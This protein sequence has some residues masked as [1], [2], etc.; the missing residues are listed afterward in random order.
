MLTLAYAIFEVL[1]TNPSGRNTIADYLELHEARRELRLRACF[2][3][4]AAKVARELDPTT[5][6]KAID[7]LKRTLSDGSCREPFCSVLRS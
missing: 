7:N 2:A 1:Q 5:V 4:K 3:R 6:R